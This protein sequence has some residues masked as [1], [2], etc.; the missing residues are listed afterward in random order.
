MDI[1]II[2]AILLAI[3]AVALIVRTLR[4]GKELNQ[5]DSAQGIFVSMYERNLIESEF[6]GKTRAEAIEYGQ[7][8]LWSEAAKFN[9][10]VNDVIKTRSFQI[11][12][13][14]IISSAIKIVK[15]V[16][17]MHLIVKQGPI[18]E[19]NESVESCE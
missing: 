7:D 11:G 4:K 19:E 5:I 13:Y 15:V 17:T 6:A 12:D 16:A 1:L 14:S 9:K 18:I 3:G 10:L 2:I 8:V